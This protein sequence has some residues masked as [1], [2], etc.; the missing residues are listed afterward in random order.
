MKTILVLAVTL[1]AASASAQDQK[2]LTF[3][4]AFFVAGSSLDV[5]STAQCYRQFA[6]CREKN[7]ANSWVPDGKPVVALLVAEDVALALLVNRFV[8]PKHRT[9]ARVLLLTAGSINLASGAHN[10]A[11]EARAR[12]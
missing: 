9:L 8:A 6:A 7:P 5:A 3:E 12:R 11:V 10:L 4:T 1:I 2:P